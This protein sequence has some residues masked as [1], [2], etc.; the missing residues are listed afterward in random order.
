MTGTDERG[1]GLALRRDEGLLEGDA[2]VASHHGIADPDQAVPV[3][4][5]RGH[6][7]DLVAAGFALHGASAQAPERLQEEGLDVVRLE[8]ARLRTL[9]VLS[10]PMDSARIHRVV[11]QG[12]LFDEILD[13][14]LIEGVGHGLVE[15][16]P[17]L[18]LLTVAN[19]LDH[20]VAEWLAIELHF[21]EHVEHL[22]AQRA[23]G[24]VE[25]LQQRPVD[26]TLAG[27]A[28]AGR[29]T[30]DGASV[31]IP[32]V[33]VPESEV[34]RHGLGRNPDV[35][36]GRPPVGSRWSFSVFWICGRDHEFLRD[37]R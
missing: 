37:L 20:E 25:L 27:R 6:M 17:N 35:L 28:A 24:L 10:Y 19:R 30:L 15:T 13:L 11:R 8:P 16:S 2:L 33:G 18:R 22:A 23:A 9:H 7:G 26:V 36:E 21:A 29:V 34:S 1:E 5:R 31:P 14:T 3:A 32:E 4:D 12:P